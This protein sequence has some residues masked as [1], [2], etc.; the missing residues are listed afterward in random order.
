MMLQFDVAYGRAQDHTDALLPQIFHD[1]EAGDCHFSQT[2]RTNVS[3]SAS[4]SL[5]GFGVPGGQRDVLANLQPFAV[6]RRHAQHPLLPASDKRMAMSPAG[7]MM[8]D[9]EWLLSPAELHGPPDASPPEAGA[10]TGG[11][12]GGDGVTKP[13][14]AVSLPASSA[15]Y[16][17]SRSASLELAA[18]AD[19]VLHG[20][21][22]GDERFGSLLPDV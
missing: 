22:A 2:P 16:L 19:G 21:A 3:D 13:V 14:S 4:P 15:G 20:R 9:A 11:S 8:P 18:L 1:T 10:A 7:N 12:G 6:S 17:A 5:H